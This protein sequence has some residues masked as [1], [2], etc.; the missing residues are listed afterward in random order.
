[1]GWRFTVPMRFLLAVMFLSLAFSGC[2]RHRAASTPRPLPAP[3]PVSSSDFTELPDV[4]PHVSPTLIV[5]P[6]TGLT[7][8]VKRV[9][10]AGRFVLLS[11]PVGHLP[12]SEQRLSV[13]RQGLKV[14]E[15]RVNDLRND[16][17]VVADVIAGDAS[18]GDEVRDR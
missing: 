16:D 9:N 13:Y 1:M 3:T 17:I 14:G 2:A 11:F 12:A 15:V 7:G 5:T 6:E 8:H 18:E 4:N 10:T